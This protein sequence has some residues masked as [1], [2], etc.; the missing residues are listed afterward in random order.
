MFFPYN[1]EDEHINQGVE[2]YQAR[3]GAAKGDEAVVACGFTFKFVAEHLKDYRKLHKEAAN[4]K[5]DDC[6]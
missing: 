4:W 2:N 1:H 6:N 3:H 5:S